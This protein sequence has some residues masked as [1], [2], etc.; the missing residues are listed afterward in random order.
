MEKKR[1]PLKVLKYRAT[2]ERS[3]SRP[4]KRSSVLIGK[5]NPDGEEGFDYT[6]HS[7]EPHIEYNFSIG[8]ATENSW[9][10]SKVIP[11]IPSTG[12]GSIHVKLHYYAT[13]VMRH[14]IKLVV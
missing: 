7:Y 11:F 5:N 6:V 10:F 8:H 1:L 14:Y 3:V 4:K 9:S 12:L 13:K 2:G